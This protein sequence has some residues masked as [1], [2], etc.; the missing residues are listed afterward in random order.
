M[1]A[2]PAL[3]ASVLI[4]HLDME[5]R[6]ANKSACPVLDVPCAAECHPMPL[7]RSE[8]RE[9]QYTRRRATEE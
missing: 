9:M 3:G 1:I 7:I 8:K 6:A 5:T 4:Q 2:S